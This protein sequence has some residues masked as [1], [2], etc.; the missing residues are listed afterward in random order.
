MKGD[1]TMEA[2]RYRRELE[3][4]DRDISSVDE[5]IERIFAEE[6]RCQDVI[7]Q[8]TRDL[9]NCKSESIIKSRQRDIDTQKSKIAALEKDRERRMMERKRLCRDRENLNQR[10]QYELQREADAQRRE[11]A[12][13]Q[14]KEADRAYWERERQRKEQKE[15][16]R[17]AQAAAYARSRT[18][19]GADIPQEMAERMVR[20]YQQEHPFSLK[21]FLCI[22]LA[23]LAALWV[24]RVLST[25][26][27][28]KERET[29]ITHQ[30]TALPETMLDHIGFTVADIENWYG[31]DYIVDSF[32]GGHYMFYTEKS[33]CPY[34]FL[35]APTDISSF[36]GTTES[37]DRICGVVSN[38]DNAIIFNNAKV[39]M[40]HREFEAEIGKIYT[41]AMDNE[42]EYDCPSA[43]FS[44]EATSFLYGKRHEYTLVILEND[45]YVCNAAIYE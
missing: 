8:R 25:G 45:G 12:E 37:D 1:N 32:S 16:K 27:D 44:V 4:K 36:D 21:K 5:A 26:P 11:V 18:N 35:F 34:S 3:R 22:A 17:Q 20:E 31:T 24:F 19:H 15:Q 7:D 33:G 23:V 9:R 42:A 10:L 2:D 14:R 30:E 40:E 29:V 39:G 38:Q 28:S 13:Q 43:T 6:K 41:A